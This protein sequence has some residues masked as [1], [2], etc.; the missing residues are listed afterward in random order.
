[1]RYPEALPVSWRYRPLLL[2]LD[3]MDA[4]TG[5]ILKKVDES[6]FRDHPD[7]VLSHWGSVSFPE[8]GKTQRQTW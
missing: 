6:S 1:M 8:S 4:S 2:A 7:E 3:G 5:L